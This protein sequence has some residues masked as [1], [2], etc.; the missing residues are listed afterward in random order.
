MDDLERYGDYNEIDEPPTKNN[1]ALIIKI[2]AAVLILAVVGVLGA[3]LFIFNYYPKSMKGLYFTTALTEYYNAQ[4][5]NI[6]A[7]TQKLL[8]PYDDNDEGN[9][10]GSNL[11]V[12]RGA[13]TLQVT[14][15][16]NVSVADSMKQNYGLS[17]FDPENREQFSFRLWRDGIS[18]DDEGREVGRLSHIEWDSFAM[19]RYAKLSFE[20]VDFGDESD[21]DKIEWIRLEI[22]VDGVQREEPFMILIYENHEERSGFDD[23]RLARG[24][25]PK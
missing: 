10:F 8:Y 11:I 16:Y 22:F 25:E 4:D 5:G 7:K 9:F 13:G 3:R 24:E 19:Y 14:L 21:P 6:D 18:E 15:R 20:D 1:G 23:Y 12:V 17:S 2:I